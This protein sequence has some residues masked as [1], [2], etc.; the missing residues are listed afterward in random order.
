MKQIWGVGIAVFVFGMTPVAQA[1]RSCR[2]SPRDM[3]QRAH[4]IA[5]VRPRRHRLLVRR[6]RRFRRGVYKVVWG[7]YGLGTTVRKI[8]VSAPLPILWSEDKS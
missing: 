8:R 1:R 5:T 4:R 6:K 2:R 3:V 7:L